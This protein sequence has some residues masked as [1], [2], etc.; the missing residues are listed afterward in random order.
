[1]KDEVRAML[2]FLR[3]AINVEYLPAVRHNY[4]LALAALAEKTFGDDNEI[5]RQAKAIE[6]AIRALRKTEEELL[7]I[8]NKLNYEL[9][10]IEER[11]KWEEISR[12][13][14]KEVRK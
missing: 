4:S 14:R 12:D 2:D 1:M 11:V 10:R 13:N 8:Y 7:H 3:G 9:G 5:T 6:Q